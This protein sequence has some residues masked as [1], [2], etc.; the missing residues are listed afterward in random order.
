MKLLHTSDWHV[1]RTIRGRSRAAE[2][3]AVLAEIAHVAAEEQVDVIIVAGDQFDSGAPSAE[4]EQIVYTALLDLVAT[5]AHVVLLAG[6]HDNPRRWKAVKPLLDLTQVHLAD[7]LMKPDEGGVIDVTVGSGEIARIALIPFLSQRSIVRADQLMA[8]DADQN[9]GRY[10]ARMGQIIAALTAD[11]GPDT[12]NI[13]TGHL[14]VAGGTPTFGGGERMAHTIF[15]YIVPPQAFPTTAQ[16]VALGHLHQPHQVPGPAPTWYCG[17]PLHLDFGE[18]ERAHKAVLVV[19]VA[20]STPATVRT[21]DLT[22][23]R[24]LRTLRG[25]L[26]QVE[27]QREQAGED[28]LRVVLDEPLR[29]GLADEVRDRFPN[30]VDVTVAAADERDPTRET[31]D[32]ESFQRSPTEV[33]AEYLAEQDITDERLTRLFGELLEDAHATDA[34]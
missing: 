4:S 32:L 17:S 33:F 28:Y 24:R 22:T 13:I 30:A 10:A 1:G 18:A 19:E 27:A 8:L 34:S 11:F 14:T 7:K 3:R 12:V 2:H 26:D 29:V 15:D 21:V 25:T 31:W 23:G 5:G 16:Y 9:A 6:N 20:P